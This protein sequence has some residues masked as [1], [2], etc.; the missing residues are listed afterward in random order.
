MQA[1]TGTDRY[2][3]L[4]G[5]TLHY[6]EWGSADAPLLVILHGLNSHSWDWDFLAS[7]LCLRYHVVALDLRGHGASDW[8]DDY[9][10]PRFQEDIEALV[11]SLGVVQF[12]LVGYSV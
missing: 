9:S 10:W 11:E 1:Q 7:S 6:R 2:G 3:T 4:N 12:T 5:L 8:A